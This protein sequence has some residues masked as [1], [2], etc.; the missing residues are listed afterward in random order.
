MGPM[1]VSKGL[2]ESLTLEIAGVRHQKT[3]VGWV[4][5]SDTHPPRL[6]GPPQSPDHE[7]SRERQQRKAQDDDARLVNTDCKREVGVT[8]GQVTH[9]LLTPPA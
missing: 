6:S 1:V 7:D 4:E 2:M 5:R 9:G 3:C 8:V